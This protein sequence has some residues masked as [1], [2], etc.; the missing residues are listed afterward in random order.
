MLKP[1]AAGTAA[2]LEAYCRQNL[3][4]YKVPRLIELRTELPKTASGKIQRFLLRQ[5]ASAPV[6]TGPRPTTLEGVPPARSP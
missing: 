6:T 3:A 4:A 2:E 5:R 1:E